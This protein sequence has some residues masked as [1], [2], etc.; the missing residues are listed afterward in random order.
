MFQLIYSRQ[1]IRQCI[2]WCVAHGK[3]T[4]SAF[5]TL[6]LIKN[7][8]ASMKL[9]LKIRIVRNA[10]QTSFYYLRLAV[11]SSWAHLRK[12]PNSNLLVS[13]HHCWNASANM[14]IYNISYKRVVQK[15]C[16]FEGVLGGM[17]PFALNCIERKKNLSI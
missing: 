7:T 14:E 9:G 11:C 13:L 12:I 1:D 10:Y 3:T 8:T 4:K 17:H 6:Q 15:I 5:L 2:F 16:S